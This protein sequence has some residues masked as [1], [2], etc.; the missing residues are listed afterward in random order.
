MNPKV[1]RVLQF[2]NDELDRQAI[3][4]L[5]RLSEIRPDK[6]TSLRGCTIPQAMLIF[7]ILDLLGYLVNEDPNAS[8]SATLTNYRVIFS[9]EHGLFPEEYEMEADRIVKLFRHGIMHQ[10]FPKASAVAKVSKGAP[11][12]GLSGNI[13]CMNVD[14][15][16][17]DFLIAFRKLRRRIESGGCDNLAERINGRLDVLCKEDY[18]ELRKLC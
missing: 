17:E 6:E 12:I 7:A 2:L 16:S 9:A 10:F 1:E 5:T 3:G 15:L 14:R 8:K 4:D 11:L 18:E 13:P